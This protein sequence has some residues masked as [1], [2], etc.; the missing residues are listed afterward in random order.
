MEQDSNSALHLLRT[1][2]SPLHQV[3]QMWSDPE[4]LT[5]WWGPDGFTSTIHE[6]DFRTGGEWRLTLHGPD[7][8]N[9]PNRS[10]FIELIPREKIV[11]EH[12]N[13]HFIT[14]VLFEAIGDKTAVRWTLLF[15]TAEMLDIVV[16]THK[17]DE[18]L[19]QNMDK[20]AN[21]LQKQRL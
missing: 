3:W 14:T 18:G 11:Y 5:Q 16:K 13:P 19:R 2:N 8:R 12:F 21:H 4:A 17:A 15:D 20:L 10:V 9:Y 6:M 1:I 7:G